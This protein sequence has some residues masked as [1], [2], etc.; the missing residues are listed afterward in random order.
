MKST[1]LPSRHDGWA[2]SEYLAVLV[3]L[4]AVWRVAQLVLDSLQR[5][6]ADF[7]WALTIPY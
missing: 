5:S 4:M 7:A 2:A 1:L 3:G 6:H